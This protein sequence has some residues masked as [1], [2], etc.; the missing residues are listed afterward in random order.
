MIFMRDVSAAGLEWRRLE[1][2]SHLVRHGTAIG[3]AKETR[4][5]VTRRAEAERWQ[6]AVRACHLPSPDLA[7][8]LL[9]AKWHLRT[10]TPTNRL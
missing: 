10:P 9:H 6:L 7:V 4:L 5:S 2:R 8:L 1:D 3:P